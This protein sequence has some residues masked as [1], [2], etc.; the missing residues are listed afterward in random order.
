MA[1]LSPALFHLL[2]CPFLPRFACRERYFGQLQAGCT[3]RKSLGF[4]FGEGRCGMYS[5][6][7]RTEPQQ[8][9]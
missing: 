6:E 2:F 7:G 9:F 1:L 8:R 5:R 3:F 4:G